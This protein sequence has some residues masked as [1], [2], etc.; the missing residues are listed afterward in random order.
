[1]ESIKIEAPDIVEYHVNLCPNCGADP[2]LDVEVKHPDTN[3][4]ILS[5][6]VVCHKCGLSASLHIWN[7]IKIM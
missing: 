6:Y 1:M 4:Y 3:K 5:R 7:R 2:E